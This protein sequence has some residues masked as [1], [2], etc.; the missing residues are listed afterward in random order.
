MFGFAGGFGGVGP[1]CCLALGDF[2]VGVIVVWVG[3]KWFIVAGWLLLGV[4]FVSFVCYA[5]ISIVGGYLRCRML[6]IVLV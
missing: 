3:L 2:L 4:Y 5:M 6:L 1:V